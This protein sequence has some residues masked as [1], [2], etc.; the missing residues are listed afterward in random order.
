MPVETVNS[1]KRMI[2]TVVRVIVA[3]MVALIILSIFTMVYHF[4][5]VHI[6][7]PSGAT[8]YYWAP[9]QLKTTMTEGFSWFRMDENG[10]N[11]KTIPDKV[12][13]LLMGSSHMEAVNVTQSDTTSSVL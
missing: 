9:N 2:K 6:S 1:K 7:N 10:F 5:G 3:G 8:D 13:I 12:D 11:N 4:T